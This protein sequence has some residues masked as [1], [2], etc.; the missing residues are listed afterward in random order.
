MNYPVICLQEEKTLCKIFL[1]VQAHCLEDYARLSKPEE[2]LEKGIEFFLSTLPQSLKK[3]NSWS[4]EFNLYCWNVDNL[5]KG[6]LKFECSTL[7]SPHDYDAYYVMDDKKIS[8]ID[9]RDCHTI[10]ELVLLN[11]EAQ[12][13][14]KT[15]KIH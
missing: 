12:N 11:T 5:E 14:K 13:L 10:E 1:I 7:L 6:L 2:K 4:Q 8:E 9:L 3:E 15:M